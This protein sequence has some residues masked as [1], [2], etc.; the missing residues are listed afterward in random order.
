MCITL[1]A[2]ESISQSF[3]S[4]KH[5]RKFIVSL[6]TGTS[7]YFGEL[8]NPKDRFDTKLNTVLGLQRF[9]SERVS[10][11]A[12]ATWFQ[13][14]GSDSEANYEGTITRNLSFISNNFEF[15]A[16]G[17]VYL[18][19]KGQRYYQRNPFNVYAYVGIGL[20]FFLILEQK[21]LN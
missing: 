19:P 21:Y 6:G 18:F 16:Q 2:V 1:N 17:I 3:Y 20:L 5:D 8:N 15:N 11:R 12:E 9:V 7:S 4:A 13:L 10:V 14:Q